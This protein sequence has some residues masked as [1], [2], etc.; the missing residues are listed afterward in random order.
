MASKISDENQ[1]PS[2]NQNFE[3]ITDRKRD[4]LKSIKSILESVKTEENEDT[5]TISD[6]NICDISNDTLKYIFTEKDISTTKD[7]SSEKE[8]SHYGP[9]STIVWTPYYEK[10]IPTNFYF[11]YNLY[12]EYNCY[13]FGEKENT[14][15]GQIYFGKNKNDEKLNENFIYNFYTSTENYFKELSPEKNNYKK[16]K[17]F[18]PKEKNNSYKYSNIK[19]ITNKNNM[20]PLL[21]NYNYNPSLTKCDIYKQ[22]KFDNKIDKMN[23]FFSNITYYNNKNYYCYDNYIS[24]NNNTYYYPKKKGKFT[25]RNGDWICNNCKNLNFA[26]RKECNR[27]KMHKDENKEN[28]EE[29]KYK[30]ITEIKE[31][32]ENCDKKIEKEKNDE[33]LKNKKKEAKEETSGLLPVK[34]GKN[35]KRKNKLKNIT[36]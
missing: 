1:Q 21:F 11:D 18:K 35:K 5:Q 10:H 13:V 24:N 6:K 23:N 17:N 12:P 14:K 19:N 29:K 7:S 32:K 34:K 25:E 20:K 2:E 27:C 9:Y 26:F 33:E 3:F 30:E 31:N 8:I 36:K 28:K 16:S 15:N 22:N 4:S